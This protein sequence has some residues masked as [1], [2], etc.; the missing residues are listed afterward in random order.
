VGNMSKASQASVSDRLLGAAAELMRK[1]GIGALSTRAIAAAAGTQPPMLYRRFGDKEGLLEAVALHIVQEYIADMRKVVE[2]SDD[3]IEHLR[4]LW[5]LYVAFAFAQP[6]CLTLIYGRT[7]RKDAISAAAETMKAMIEQ[8]IARVAD[9]GRLGMSVES[10]TALFR[11]C[12][13]GFV[14]TQAKIPAAQRDPELS[15]IVRETALAR[16]AVKS[17]AGE[18]RSTLT[19]RAAAMRH[20]IEGEDVPLTPA[21]HEVMAEWLDRIANK[22]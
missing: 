11:S 10:A 9:D 18:T 21:E 1:G 12:G 13:V 17:K 16:I 2:V 14:L 22:P 7:G 20:A 8:A 4:N 6:D 3:P 5:D 15:V 19:A